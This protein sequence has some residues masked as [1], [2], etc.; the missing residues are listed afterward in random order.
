M[1]TLFSS[2][3]TRGFA[4]AGA[5]FLSACGGGGDDLTLS[6]TAAVG[7]P[8][9]GGTVDVKCAAGSALNTTTTSAGTWTV[10]LNG[11]TLP[12]AVR[13]SGG[14]VNGSANGTAYH[15]I[16]ITAGTVNITPLTDLVVA[17]IVQGSPSAWFT[18]PSFT[19]FTAQNV[20]A[21]VNLL[22]SQLGLSSALGSRDPLTSAFS[23][24]G[25]DA[26]D[27]ALDA[28]ADALAALGATY[29]DLLEAAQFDF[30]D[31]EDF[32][33]AFNSAWAALNTSS[34]GSGTSGGSG[35]GG[36]ST[37]G[38]SGGSSS[39]TATLL[40]ET[41]MGN[42]TSPITSVTLTNVPRPGSQ[43]DFCAAV[44]NDPSLRNLQTPGASLTVNQCT[45]SGNVG[46]VS[47]TITVT[48]P[49]TFSTSYTVRY[50]YS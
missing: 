13:V 40:V 4:L 10:T 42:A 15:S 18:A 7:A 46:T 21:S 43:T 6:G 38:S 36:G 26:L 22:R 29:A 30:R 45:F 37:G 11:Q 41:F 14:T 9:V 8:I 33:S 19:R 28:F 39:G 23:A 25:T 32:V 24:N 50:T 12:C 49:V 31:R 48:S 3:L 16:A 47:L 27:K 5:L 2:P 35:G 17:H 44:N 20:S 1:R 34:G